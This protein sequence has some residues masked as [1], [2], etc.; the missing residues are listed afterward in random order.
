MYSHPMPEHS[1]PDHAGLSAPLGT[2]SVVHSLRAHSTALRVP[3]S[4]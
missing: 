2:R 4:V 1:A 3:F